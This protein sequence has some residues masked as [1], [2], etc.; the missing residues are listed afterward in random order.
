M[1]YK[2]HKGFNGYDVYIIADNINDKTFEFLNKYID[3]SKIIRTSLGNSGSFLYSA[4]FAA[5]TFK[6]DNNVYFAED[7]YLYLDN[8]GAV[9]EDGLRFAEYSSG[10]DHLDKYI[11][12]HEG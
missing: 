12:Y 2:F 9:I 8:A 6:D 3:S 10:Y 4:S 7:D 5:N 1:F 11:N